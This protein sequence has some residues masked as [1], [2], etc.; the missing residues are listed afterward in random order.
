MDRAMSEGPHELIN[1]PG[2]VR[3]AGFS[4]VVVPA[5][6]RTVYLAGQTGHRADGT[7]AGPMLVEQ[8][9]QALANVVGALAG[10][11]GHP[12]DLVRVHIYVTDASDYRGR[13]GALGDAWRRHL[14]SHYPAVALFEVAGLFDPD[15]RVELVGTAVVPGA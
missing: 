5:E 14:G 15:A 10:A 4:H 9:D 1:P 3:P 2:L 8:F 6:G 11:G 12:Q 13:L 7:L